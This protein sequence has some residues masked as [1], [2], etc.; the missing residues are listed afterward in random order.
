MATLTL[1]G[2]VFLKCFK[3]LSCR[4]FLYFIC[5]ISVVLC[6]VLFL[7]ATLLAFSTTG[8]FYSCKYLGDTFTNPTSFQSTV[9]NLFGGSYSNITAYFSQCFGGN[10]NF[11]TSLNPTLSGYVLQM[12]NSV[13]K[14]HNYNFTTVNT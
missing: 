5:I 11:L 1:V 8:V 2:V 9:T 10:Y 12:Q 4:H 13:S 14:A 7:V 6:I 3:W